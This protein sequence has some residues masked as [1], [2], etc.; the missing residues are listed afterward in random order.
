MPETYTT[1]VRANTVRP[2]LDEIVDTDN[3]RFAVVSRT[4]KTKWT[5]ILIEDGRTMRVENDSFLRIVRER[6][7]AEEQEQAE[8]KGKL[9]WLDTQERGAEAGLEKAKQRLIETVAG[10]SWN[11]ASRM[12][13]LLEAKAVHALWA[14]VTQVHLNH[15][16][17]VTLEPITRLE[18]HAI[19]LNRVRDEVLD[20]TRWS[21]RST[22]TWSNAVEDLELDV[23]SRFL[24][25]AKWHVEL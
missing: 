22:S 19:V 25:D 20:F 10:D 21:S 1:D 7:T 14:R 13:D 12:Q 6:A 5:E 4:S 2:K 18:A 16:T 9:H 23:K 3:R 11:V 15:I 24:R 17:A 8:L